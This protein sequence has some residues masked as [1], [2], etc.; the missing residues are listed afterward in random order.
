LKKDRL[1]HAPDPAAPVVPKH[2]LHP[3]LPPGICV[4]SSPLAG[5]IW[6]VAWPASA[7]VVG[8]FA[9]VELALNQHGT[10]V[11]ILTYCGALLPVSRL[12]VAIEPNDEASAVHW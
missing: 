5:T 4:C 1:A 6:L 3:V 11:A 7:A 9:P 8:M 10:L 2:K 12:P